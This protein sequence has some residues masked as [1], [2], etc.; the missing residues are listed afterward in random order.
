MSRAD[1]KPRV[2][3]IS[4]DPAP[5]GLAACYH[6]A[7]VDHGK[8]T[9]LHFLFGEK[10]DS[11][12]ASA[13]DRLA[14]LYRVKRSR[15][16]RRLEAAVAAFRPDLILVIKG[17]ELDGDALSKLK[18]LSGALLF[19]VYPDSPFVYPGYPD[20]NGESFSSVLRQYDCLFTF[21]R[22]LLPVFALCG[23]PQVR[24][25][26]FAHDPSLHRPL[27]LD[28]LTIARYGSPVAY[29]GTWGPSHERWLDTLLPFGLKI[30]GLHWDHLPPS[31]PLRDCWQR[32]G[33][34]RH[35]LGPSMAKICGA[36]A[37]VFNLIRAEHGCAHSMKTFEIPACQGLMVTNRT[38]EQLEYFPE[39]RCAVYFSTKEELRDKVTFYLKVESV[40]EK[41]AREGYRRS[42]GH[43]YLHRVEDVLRAYRE[44]R[45]A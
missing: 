13:F 27:P 31:S 8:E 11:L 29:L 30:W 43:T 44:L 26:P 42:L 4:S 37:I 20:L 10:T 41:I 34:S 38:D 5:W 24:Y 2:F 33:S 15:A 18:T 16:L 12:L 6:R 3:L 32:P 1:G 17:T 7:F 22:F 19:N 25:L 23:A 40:R 14:P 36:S 21:A 35:G 39:D 9:A 45:R 28:A